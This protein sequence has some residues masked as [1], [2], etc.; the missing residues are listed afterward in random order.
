MT[1]NEV[2]FPFRKEK[3]KNTTKVS[4]IITQRSDDWART[5]LPTRD[6][7][8]LHR[9]HKI[10]QHK[11]YYKQ[12]ITKCYT[13]TIRL[14][15]TYTTTTK[16]SQNTTH[17]TQDWVTQTLLQTRNHKILHR[18]H[19]IEQHDPYYNQGITKHYT[20]NIRLSNTNPTTTKGSQNTTQKT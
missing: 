9:E 17:K 12:G 16:V 6:R 14:S 7:K 4:Q 3:K 15:N 18:K 1:G 19:K 10:E 5:P 8:A 11:P 2:N 20:K 13:E